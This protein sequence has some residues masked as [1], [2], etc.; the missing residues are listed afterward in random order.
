MQLD[1]ALTEAISLAHDLGHPPFGHIGEGI[2][3]DIM[4]KNGNNGF[5]HNIQ[6][7]RII[8]KL[9]QKYAAF[10]GLNLTYETL[11]DGPNHALV[12]L[13]Q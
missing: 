9:E 6:T 1:E 12:I 3:N 13:L 5:N 11:E 2:L 8:T 10:D 7:L 4:L